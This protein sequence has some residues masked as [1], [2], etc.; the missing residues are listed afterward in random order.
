ML[1]TS[2]DDLTR[3]IGDKTGASYEIAHFMMSI[4]DWILGIFGL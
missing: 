3:F 1:S 2:P 4:V